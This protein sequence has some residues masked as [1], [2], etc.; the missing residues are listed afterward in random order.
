[1]RLTSLFEICLAVDSHMAGVAS[2][3]HK[4]PPTLLLPLQPVWCHGLT[5]FV[6]LCLILAIARILGASHLFPGCR[7]F[8]LALEPAQEMPL[9]RFHSGSSIQVINF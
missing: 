6:T 8:L 3:I 2:C 9:V 4:V 5:S 7:T 1:M